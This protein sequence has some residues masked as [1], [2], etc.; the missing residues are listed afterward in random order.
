[1]KLAKLYWRAAACVLAI[2]L[3][4]AASAQAPG[5]DYSVIKP[6]QPTTSGK[7]VEV[8]E[9][10]W[11]GCPHCN[12][13]QPTLRVWLKRK[14]ADVEFKREPAVLNDSWLPLT[15]AFHA[16]EA[17]GIE[18]KLHYELFSAIH[19]Q[20]NLEIKGLLR[21]QKPLFDWVAKQGVDR[22]QFADMFNSFAVRTRTNR[23]I[24]MTRN[25][26]VPGTPALAVDGKYLLMLSHALRPD[27]N[28]DYERF[29]QL[30][31]Q[32]IARARKERAGK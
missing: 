5:K 8:I 28:V 25:Y 22:K 6:P 24:E 15:T 3:S 16:L 27:N 20:H 18:Q 11:Y 26:E 29:T 14:P 10:F 21:D 9:F 31:D 13:L 7:K 17:M 23:S 2:T 19:E 32:L 12:A 30:L 4:A 1:M